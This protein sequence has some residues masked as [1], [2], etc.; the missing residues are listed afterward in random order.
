M[1]SFTTSQHISLRK[2]WKERL[3]QGNGTGF[4]QTSFISLSG[5][6]RLP[7]PG[8][9]DPFCE[10]L[11]HNA[12]PRTERPELVHTRTSTYC[13]IHAR[14]YGFT[15]LRSYA[16]ID[17][18]CHTFMVGFFVCQVTGELFCKRFF[19][20][21]LTLKTLQQKIFKVEIEESE[22]VGVA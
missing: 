6:R 13:Q 1:I 21:L 5:G 15:A 18:A 19:K 12:L 17:D 3:R 22:T 9:S 2:E 8:A 4:A 20:M 14:L 10:N 7:G 16:R 11:Y